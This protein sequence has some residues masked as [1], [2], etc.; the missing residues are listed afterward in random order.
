MSIN[1]SDKKLY[2]EIQR[3]NIPIVENTQNTQNQLNKPQYIENNIIVVEKKNKTLSSL[4]RNIIIV[5]IVIVLVYLTIYR[6]VI[7]YDFFKNKEYMKSAAVL[8]P[9]LT[10]LSL[11]VL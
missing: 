2:T 8:S 9:E 4:I 11:L 3:A 1:L 6:F 5:L 7:S 10:S